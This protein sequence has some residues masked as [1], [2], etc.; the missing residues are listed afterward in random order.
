MVGRPSDLVISFYCVLV[1]EYDKAATQ[2]PSILGSDATLWEHWI[3]AFAEAR[4][5]KVPISVLLEINEEKLV[6]EELT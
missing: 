5:L 2:C 4:Q 1:E 3:Y 6:I